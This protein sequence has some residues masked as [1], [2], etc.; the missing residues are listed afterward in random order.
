[1]N[2]AIIAFVIVWTSILALPVHARLMRGVRAWPIDGTEGL[3]LGVLL[4]EDTVYAPR[5]SDSGF[6]HVVLGMSRS[7]VEALI[8]APQ[9]KWPTD[10][11][12]DHPDVGAR[13][14]YSPGDTHFRCRVL[15]FRNGVVV[16]K[17][18][19]FYVD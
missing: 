5:Y 15:L 6:R 10:E 17:H 9:R 11:H 18:S 13:W 8:G 19:D 7:Q 1:M 3:V 12:T 4:G 14:S 2:R 16:E